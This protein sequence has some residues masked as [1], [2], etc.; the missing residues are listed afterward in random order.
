MWRQWRA[1]A[2]LLLCA[3]R[4]KS[5]PLLELHCRH[6][7]PQ[8][9]VVGARTAFF[10]KRAAPP[11]GCL[12]SA[13]RPSPSLREEEKPAPG[14]RILQ[15]PQ[16]RSNLNDSLKVGGTTG[17]GRSRDQALRPLRPH[18]ARKTHQCARRH[19]FPDTFQV[20]TGASG[21]CRTHWPVSGGSVSRGWPE[22]GVGPPKS[23]QLSTRLSK[24]GEGCAMVPPP[25]VTTTRAACPK[26]P[27]EPR[28]ECPDHRTQ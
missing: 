17:K 18:P 25:P 13:H 7:L 4:R 16:S 5:A 21:A 9:V 6:S 12:C 20:P 26:P 1:G 2:G 8:A 14:A 22:G 19:G 15:A 11:G 27:G 24:A 23:H 28:S 3:H 10:S